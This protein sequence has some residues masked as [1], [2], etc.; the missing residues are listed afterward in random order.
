MLDVS[1][2]FIHD[3]L[4]DVWSL[5]D[6]HGKMTVTVL[7]KW[8]HNGAEVSVSFIKL[9]GVVLHTDIQFGKNL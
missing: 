3:L 7:A 6:P 1:K 9:E 4:C 8:C 2:E 5:L